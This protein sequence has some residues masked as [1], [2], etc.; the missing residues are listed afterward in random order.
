MNHNE[1]DMLVLGAS[2]GLLA[3]TFVGYKL[4]GLREFI[5]NHNE[6][7]RGIND[8]QRSRQQTSV[9][10]A[11]RSEP[12]MPAF[13]SLPKHEQHAPKRNPIA[14]ILPSSPDRDDV[15]AALVSAGFKKV[16]AITSTDGC[17]LSERTAGVEAWTVAALR[18][19][20]RK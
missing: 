8:H 15:I 12:M 14:D 3:G 17:L 2:A 1:I 5:R 9:R 13:V 19:A 18:R 16:V 11:R 4:R 10:S 20:A 7:V 6:E